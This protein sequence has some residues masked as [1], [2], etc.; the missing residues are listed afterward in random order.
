MPQ[1]E[2]PTTKIHNYVLGGFGDKKE[3]KKGNHI[4]NKFNSHHFQQIFTKG[5]FRAKNMLKHQHHQQQQQK[6]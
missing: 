4:A 3:K 2:G 5:S 1:L 6:W